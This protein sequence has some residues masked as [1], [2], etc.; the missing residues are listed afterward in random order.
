MTW[1]DYESTVKIIYE[2]LGKTAGVNIECYGHNCKRKGKSSV[3]HQIDVITSHSDGIHNYFTGIECKYWDQKVN[4]DIVM[5]VAEVG[6]DC[7]FSKMVVV[8]KEGFTPDTITFAKYKN[9]HLVQLKEHNLIISG[10]T[11]TKGFLI[12]GITEPQIFDVQVKL[13]PEVLEENSNSSFLKG[14]RNLFYI[15]KPDGQTVKITKLINDF[16][17]TE[18]VISKGLDFL[19]QEI[20]FEEGTVIKRDSSEMLVPVIGIYLKGHPVHYSLLATDYFDNNVW[21]VMKLLFEEKDYE[22]TTDGQIKPRRK[23][24]EIIGVVGQRIRIHPTIIK[25][26]FDI[27]TDKSLKTEER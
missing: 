12:L 2:Q 17:N 20:V 10:S 11:L 5:K 26:E 27:L 22:F 15:Q 16:L 23:G 1:Q 8:S 18:V 7:Q 3:L 6:E 24:P 13:S 4:K 14:D 19:E 25:K 9:V 21:L